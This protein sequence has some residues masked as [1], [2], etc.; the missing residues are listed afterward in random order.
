MHLL[1]ILE[2]IV[3]GHFK[4]PLIK[5]DPQKNCQPKRLNRHKYSP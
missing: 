1:T 2:S 5:T 4:K 3:H